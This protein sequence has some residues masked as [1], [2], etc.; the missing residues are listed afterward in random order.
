MQVFLGDCFFY[1]A[2]YICA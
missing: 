2:P 1:T